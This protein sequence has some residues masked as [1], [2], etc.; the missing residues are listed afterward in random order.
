MVSEVLLVTYA[1]D[2]N[3]KPSMPDDVGLHTVTMRF[4]HSF[5][6]QPG[7]GDTVRVVGDELATCRKLM[8]HP[9]SY[10]GYHPSPDAVGA[11]VVPSS[12]ITRDRLLDRK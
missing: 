8:L 3:P 5:V 6:V 1:C 12:G 10:Q 9:A 7:L 2:S 4:C 11:P